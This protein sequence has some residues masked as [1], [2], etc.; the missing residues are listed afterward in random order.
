MDKRDIKLVT[1]DDSE[2]VVSVGDT[3]AVGFHRHGSVGEDA[4]FEIANDGIIKFVREESEY[5]HPERLDRGIT[6]GDAERCR[7]LF[8]AKQAGKTK[9][10]VR[11]LFRFRVER[12]VPIT[13]IVE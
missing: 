8:V 5:L 11:E 3:F 2:L 4:E 6:G 7:W 9:I 10:I 13:V 12:E 1:M